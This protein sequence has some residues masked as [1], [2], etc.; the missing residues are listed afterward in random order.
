MARPSS[1]TPEVQ[2]AELLEKLAKLRE[3]KATSQF[4]SNPLVSKLI[5]ERNVLD[6]QTKEAQKGL[7][8]TVP[9]YNLRARFESA[10]RK[11]EMIRA[12]AI[13]SECVVRF[14]GV[15]EAFLNSIISEAISKLGKGESSDSVQAWIESE[16]ET[17]N[18]AHLELVGEYNSKLLDYTKAERNYRSFLEEKENAPR[19]ARGRKSED[20]GKKMSASD[21][22][23]MI[24]E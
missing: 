9:N 10:K 6:T 7:F 8:S 1:K 17:F 18:S 23:G 3:S 12:E 15:K 22:L 2:E 11:L 19:A 5:E 4:I 14:G 13:L 16:F 21:V 24:L 20:E